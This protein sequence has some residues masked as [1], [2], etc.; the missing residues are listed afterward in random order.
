MS[1]FGSDG[2][3][4]AARPRNAGF[5]FL[6]PCRRSP[7]REVGERSRGRWKRPIFT[8]GLRHSFANF[9][10]SRSCFHLPSMVDPAVVRLRCVRRFEATDTSDRTTPGK[11]W[12]EFGSHEGIRVQKRMWKNDVAQYPEGHSVDRIQSESILTGKL[13][14]GCRTTRTSYSGK[15]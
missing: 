9:T 3:M 10:A 13:L 15:S 11:P 14:D 8:G 2:K 7:S 6:D 5:E 4:T 1:T 12:M